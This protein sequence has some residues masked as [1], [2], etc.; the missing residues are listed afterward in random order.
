MSAVTASAS[1][2]NL[3]M[4]EACAGDDLVGVVSRQQRRDLNP[5]AGKDYCA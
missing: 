1:F 2:H 5:G 3:V 4:Q